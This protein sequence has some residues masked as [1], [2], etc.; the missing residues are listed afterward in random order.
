MAPARDVKAR[1]EPAPQREC[2][3]SSGERRSSGKIVP[4]SPA[5]AMSSYSGI[6]VPIA[7]AA[8]DQP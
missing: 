8:N 6:L 5:L 3:A 7:A 1:K 2:R 4:V